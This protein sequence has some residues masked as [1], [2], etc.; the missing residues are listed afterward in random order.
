MFK[1]RGKDSVGGFDTLIGSKVRVHGD[2]EFAGGM[3]VDGYV[4]GNVRAEGGADASLSISEEGVIDGSVEAQH[5]IANGRVN[6]DILATGRVV[7]GAKARVRGDVHYDVIEM[8]LGAEISGKLK[9][10]AADGTSQTVQVKKA[11][12]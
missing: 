4:I 7:L 11:A 10:R 8:A 9:K 1:R 2:I 3:H 12:N 5:V 6:G